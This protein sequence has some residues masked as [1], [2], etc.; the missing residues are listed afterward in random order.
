MQDGFFFLGIFI[1]LFVVW[2]ATGGPMRPISF[3]GP[4]LNPIHTTGTTAQP[5]GDPS[6]YSS[7]NSTV[8]VG[9]NGVNASPN[10]S[11]S[12]GAITLSRDTSGAMSTDPDQEYVVINVSAGASGN[13][14]TAGWKLVSRT[15]GDGASFP[16]GAEVPVSG[17]VNALSAILLHPGDQAIVATGR[18]PVGISFR[19]NECTGYLEEHQDFHPALSMN[20]PTPSQEFSSYYA[21]SDDNGSCAAFVRSIPYCGT[22]TPSSANISSS[23]QDFVD[24]RLNYNACV[25]THHADPGFESTVWRIFLG[26]NDELWGRSHETIALLDAQGKVIDSLTY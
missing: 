22:E 1:L 25:N 5:Y 14:S 24:E 21:K 12:A 18:S 4:Y 8:T 3:A 20:C 17:R 13:V 6:Q 15:S 7:I 10:T 11:A 23:C 2:V 19:E 26:Q 9:L 16:Q